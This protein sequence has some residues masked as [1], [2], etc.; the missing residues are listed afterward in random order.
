[1]TSHGTATHIQIATA[2]ANIITINVTISLPDP[3]RVTKSKQGLQ[4]CVMQYVLRHLHS[5]M[6]M[7]QAV[8]MSFAVRCDHAQIGHM[9]AN[10]AQESCNQ[11]QPCCIANADMLA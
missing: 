9:H 1:M 8:Y 11:L 5:I 3:Y 7:R 10:A 4:P 2:F 6:Y